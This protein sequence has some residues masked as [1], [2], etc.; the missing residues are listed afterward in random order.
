[1]NIKSFVHAAC[2]CCALAG[3]SAWAQ[4]IAPVQVTAWGRHHGA[5]VVYTYEVRNLG[6]RP[7]KRLSVG[8]C[9]SGGASSGAEL[10]VAPSD[11]NATSWLSNA[12]ARS[13]EGWGAAIE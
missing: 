7:I 3:T 2:A 12:V 13:P 4:A 1:M 9:P 8:H 5:Q 11:T 10:S 6:S